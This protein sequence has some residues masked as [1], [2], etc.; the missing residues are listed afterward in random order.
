MLPAA[1]PNC[2]VRSQNPAGRIGRVSR[3]I[4]LVS[5]AVTVSFASPTGSIST[6]PLAPRSK[7]AG[8]TMFTEIPPEQSGVVAP[9][10]Y[11]DPRMWGELYHEFE[12]GAIGTGVAV[13]DYDGDGRPDL[14]VVSK[15]ESCRL[16]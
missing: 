8:A 15:T 10:N 12:I 4:F 14:F 3:I 16:F 11:S 7:P 1:K 9:N 2:P 5:A 6:A 13:G